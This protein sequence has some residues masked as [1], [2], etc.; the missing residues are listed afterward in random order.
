MRLRFGSAERRA[1]TIAHWRSRRVTS[2]SHSLSASRCRRTDGRSIVSHVNRRKAV[3]GHLFPALWPR[4]SPARLSIVEFFLLIRLRFSCPV[5]LALASPLSASPTSFLSSR[6]LSSSWLFPTVH[7]SSSLFPAFYLPTVSVC[8]SLRLQCHKPLGRSHSLLLHLFAWSPI[9]L[10][11]HFHLFL[12]QRCPS[13]FSVSSHSSV[14]ESARRLHPEVLSGPIPEWLHG[15]KH[16]QSSK[17]RWLAKWK[18][19][20]RQLL[21]SRICLCGVT[22]W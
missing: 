13:V 6:R 19:K 1:Q 8:R 12:P 11:Q 16:V 3:S 20:L 10:Y 5:V 17:R 22:V 9:S 14:Q 21:S 2:P 4:P 7:L 15:E 18:F